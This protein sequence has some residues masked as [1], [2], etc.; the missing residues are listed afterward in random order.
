M[1]AAAGAF[2]GGAD[3]GEIAVPTTLQAL[4]GSRLDALPADDKRI[5]QH[6]SVV[7]MVF[8]AGAVAELTS[9]SGELD[10]SLRSLEATEVI[11]KQAESTVADDHEWQFLHALIR[12]VAYGRVPKGRRANLHVRLAD[13]L[14]ARAGTDEEF[15]EIVAYH[16]EQACKLAGA[17]GRSEVPPPVE[18][19][20][21]ALM[22]AAEKAERR[23]GIR[24]ADR[25]YARA[26]ELVGNED[27]EQALD[28]RLRRGGTL[29]LLGDQQ[30]A[31][32]LLSRA[33]D[34]ART[35]GRRDLLGAALIGRSNIARKRGQAAVARACLAEAEA[36]ATELADL[37]L[38]V[39]VLYELA[40]VAWAFDGS[41][42]AAL[43]RFRRGLQLA[44]ELGDQ[45][46]QVEG[47]LW[48]VVPLYNLGELEKAEEQLVR[49]SELVSELGGLRHAARA[50][51]QLGLVKYHLGAIEEAEELGLQAFDWLERTGEKFVQLQNLRTLA[52]CALERSD[53]PLAE[54]R[55]QQAIPLALEIGGVQVVETYRCLIVVLLRKGQLDDARELAAFA[56]RNLPED[57][58]YARTAGLLI[59][60][61][62]ATADGDR[63]ALD[64]HFGEAVNL[65]QLQELPLDLGEARLAYGRALRSVGN[66]ERAREELLLARDDLMRAGARGL[67]GQIEAELS[68]LTEG[69]GLADPL[70]SA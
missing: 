27:V 28:V 56:L 69:A 46:L 4:I 30:A 17:V 67:V 24:E 2:S 64:A 60:A 59:R 35:A 6:A 52:M 15:V 66:D 43:E 7:G 68:G 18:R 21:E 10:D 41:S 19:A 63:D 49:A 13:W 3:V 36:I 9:G 70:A 1:L 5:A 37:S 62:I 39:R 50:A 57:D 55:L 33:A 32:E 20:V 34:D 44:E 38:Q 40:N 25:Y 51:F 29:R 42:D 48:M 16:L 31:D 65:L 23:E 12:D 45:N 26:L 11:Q 53:L 22:R 47:H 54:E 14:V 8:W 61:S 58:V